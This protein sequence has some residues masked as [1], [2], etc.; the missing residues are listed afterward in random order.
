MCP[1]SAVNSF[2]GDSESISVKQKPNC[3]NIL[4][5]SVSNFHEIMFSVRCESEISVGDLHN[6]AS[7][8]QC[9]YHYVF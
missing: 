4:S 3:V 2:R 5:N 8:L 9:D 7:D 1:G 6:W